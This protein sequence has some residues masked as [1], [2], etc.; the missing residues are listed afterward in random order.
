MGKYI[1]EVDADLY[2]RAVP[3]SPKEAYGHDN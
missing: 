3:T 1:N 2:G